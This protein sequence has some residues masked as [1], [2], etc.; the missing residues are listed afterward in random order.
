MEKRK[1]IRLGR[2]TLVISIPS[3]WVR[4]NGLNPGDTINLEV[5][6]DGALIIYPSEARTF[7]NN[8]IIIYV[9]QF[10]S[11]GEIAREIL[12][13]YLNGYNTI[14]VVSSKVLTVRQQKLVRQLA[15][16]LYMNIIS[17]ASSEMV[18]QSLL[19]LSKIPL[20]TSLTR[21]YTITY[22]MFSDLVKA[23]ENYDHD[24]AV[25]IISLDDEVDNFS[26]LL[27]RLLRTML[28]HS[29]T[30]EQIKISRN[31]CLDGLIVVQNIEY[32]A[33]NIVNVAQRFLGIL[34]EKR[35]FPKELLELLKKLCEECI[36]YY[37]DAFRAYI[38]VDSELSNRILERRTVFNEL[39]LR[40]LESL[41]KQQDPVI[42]C[43]TCTINSNIQAI[44]AS[45]SRI[46]EA[47]INKHAIK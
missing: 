43:T 11:D 8:E 44:I 33:D 6:N 27:L 37:D 5:Q 12:S 26:Y 1:L 36:K 25:A 18:M 24:L 3:D 47:A 31:S 42:V 40:I 14:K 34:E 30:S 23:L 7:M 13:Y 2:S 39:N 17:A 45:S 16:K 35:R 29:S 9:D 38:S 15:Q 21:M 4:I 28:T 46:A 22:S 19:D 20:D 41:I 10:K 32:I